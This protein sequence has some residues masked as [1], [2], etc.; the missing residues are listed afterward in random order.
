MY[1]I[2]NESLRIA[3]CSIEDLKATQIRAF[4]EEC[5]PGASINMLTLFYDDENRYVVLNR[6]HKNFKGYLELTRAYMVLNDENR[7]LIREAVQMP[8]RET[9]ECLE[10]AMQRMKRSV[11]NNA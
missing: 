4:L 6:D 8:I 2:E 9:I 1:K 11:N 5:K 7:G 10:L 3:S